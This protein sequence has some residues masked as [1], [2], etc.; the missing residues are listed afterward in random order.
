MDCKAITMYRNLEV[1]A[2]RQHKA[3]NMEKASFKFINHETF[4]NEKSFFM[5]KPNLKVE[6]TDDKAGNKDF[7]IFI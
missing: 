4:G 1:Q 3:K 7:D 2:I 6:S 5:S